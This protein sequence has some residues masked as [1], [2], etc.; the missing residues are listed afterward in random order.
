MTTQL[1][2][3]H[4][5]DMPV[6]FQTDAFINAT[7]IAKQF[8]KFPKDYLKSERTKEYIE[9]IRRII[10]IEQNQL[11]IVRSGSTENGGG[12]W[13][14]PKLAIDFARWLDS[15]FAVWCDCQIEKILRLKTV[16]INS[17]LTEIFL[18]PITES[19]TLADFNWR[20]EVIYRAF[21]NLEKAQAR[22]RFEK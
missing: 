15:D 9:S 18:K 20:K 6:L 4:F 7:A 11:V 8:N 13:L 17:D 14:H 1:I 10:L 5:G 3:T 2:T 22:D 12:T 21:K 16:P 19:I